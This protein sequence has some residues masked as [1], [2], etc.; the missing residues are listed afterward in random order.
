MKKTIPILLAIIMISILTGCSTKIEYKKITAEEAQAMMDGDVIILDVRTQ[1][2]FNNGH[3][4][5]AILIPDYEIKEKIE[6]IISNK[7]KTILVYCKTGVRSEKVARELIDLGYINVYDFGGI[8]A[9]RGE[10]VWDVS[11]AIFYNYFGGE[12]PSNVV[13]SIDYNISKKINDKKQEFKFNL[14]GTYTKKYCLTSDK[15]RYYEDPEI[16]ISKI[17]I[18]SNDGVFKQE[19]D[20]EK[21]FLNHFDEAYGFKLEDWNF[22]GYLD[23]SLWQTTGGSM[24]NSPHYYWIW[25]EEKGEFIRNSHLE[26]ISQSATL[27]IDEENEHI[28]ASTRISSIEYYIGYYKAQQSGKYLLVKTEEHKLYEPGDPKEGYV[29][30]IIKE[31]VN[32]K[33][34]ITKE[35]DENLNKVD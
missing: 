13:E 25:D 24:L 8:E 7:N 32:G 33:M 6:E 1:E 2:E 5:N 23:I 31:L 21:T 34:I 17:I 28:I 3:I 20:F 19:L 18:T 26:E 9:W 10:I 22:D 29:H 11:D 30:Y 12:L 35:Y 14:K 4:R 16:E 27:Q 15:K